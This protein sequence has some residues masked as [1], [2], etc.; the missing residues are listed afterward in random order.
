M[1]IV[2]DEEKRVEIYMLI[3]NKGD[4]D[5]EFNIEFNLNLEEPAYVPKTAMSGLL[6]AVLYGPKTIFADFFGPYK[7]KS[8]E[9]ML[10]AQRYKYK[11]DFANNYVISAILYNSEEEAVDAISYPLNLIK[12]K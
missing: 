4:K 5:E 10:L 9:S 2:Y 11:D 12:I 3:L 8:G 7:I 6:G 1:P